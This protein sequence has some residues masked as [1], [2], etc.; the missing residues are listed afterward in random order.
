MRALVAALAA[1]VLA[2][3][4]IAVA[5]RDTGPSESAYREAFRA[6]DTRLVAAV[7]RGP[8]VSS[9]EQRAQARAVERAAAQL[10]D[11]E[12]PDR[13]RADHEELL[14]ALRTHSVELR[15]AAGEIH[16]PGTGD[17]ALDASWGRL[18]RA[19]TRLRD[20]FVR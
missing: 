3:V 13:I 10:A 19:W 4:A 7:G 20:E 2:V 15:R 17:P 8:F 1:A 9:A 5:G 18:S 11:A 14:A 16:Q 6:V 12:P